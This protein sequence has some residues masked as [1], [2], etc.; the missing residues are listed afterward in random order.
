MNFELRMA[1]PQDCIEWLQC[2]E[3]YKNF[4][5]CLKFYFIIFVIYLIF[6][7]YGLL[8]VTEWLEFNFM[9]FLIDFIS[10]CYDVSHHDV[11]WKFPQDPW[12]MKSIT[13]DICFTGWHSFDKWWWLSRSKAKCWWFFFSSA[14]T[15]P[16]EV[17]MNCRLLNFRL[18]CYFF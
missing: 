4:S 14:F 6:G 11:S 9:T 18:L 16:K 3:G 12:Y 8:Y 1:D 13:A 7:C 5:F 17:L 15:K 10:V 2:L